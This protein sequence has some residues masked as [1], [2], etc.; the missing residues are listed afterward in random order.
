MF[1]CSCRLH[2]SFI[3]FILIYCGKTEDWSMLFTCWYVWKLRRAMQSAVFML[4]LA[5][6]SNKKISKNV[7]GKRS[8]STFSIRVTSCV[9]CKQM[10]TK[11]AQEIWI[12]VATLHDKTSIILRFFFSIYSFSHW[13]RLHTDSK[14]D[15]D[16]I[17]RDLRLLKLL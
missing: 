13:L 15:H 6:E 16:L 1:C 12:Y 8:N 11:V 17:S 14:S 5:L 7:S 3:L 4:W 10:N 2:Q 9:M